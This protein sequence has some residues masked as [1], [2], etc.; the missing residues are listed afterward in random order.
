[1]SLGHEREVDGGRP[2][3]GPHEPRLRAVRRAPEAEARGAA[4]G[5]LRRQTER[6]L[7]ALRALRADHV[8]LMTYHTIRLLNT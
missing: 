6:T 8:L 3:A 4:R 1:M 5:V 2:E 7:R